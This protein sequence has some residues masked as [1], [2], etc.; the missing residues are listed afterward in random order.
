ML[1]ICRTFFSFYMHSDFFKNG[2]RPHGEPKEEKKSIGIESTDTATRISRQGNE[3]CNVC[4][5]I[6]VP[7]E[8]MVTTSNGRTEIRLADDV[9][10]YVQSWNRK[11]LANRLTD[12]LSCLI[13]CMTKNSYSL[14]VHE[15]INETRVKMP[16][17]NLRLIGHEGNSLRDESMETEF[18]E[19][20]NLV[21]T[22]SYYMAVSMSDAESHQSSKVITL[23]QDKTDNYLCDS[24]DTETSSPDSTKSQ[25]KRSQ[26]DS[27]ISIP[28]SYSQG[29]CS[30]TNSP[31]VKKDK[32]LKKRAAKFSEHGKYAKHS[33]TQTSTQSSAEEVGNTGRRPAPL[34]HQDSRE[35]QAFPSS[36]GFPVEGSMDDY[37]EKMNS[38]NTSNENLNRRGEEFLQHEEITAAED[39]LPESDVHSPY[40]EASGNHVGEISEVFLGNLQEQAEFEQLLPSAEDGDSVDSK[41]GFCVYVPSTSD[42][43]R[44]AILTQPERLKQSDNTSHRRDRLS[45]QRKIDGKDPTESDHNSNVIPD[46]S[47]DW[48]HDPSSPVCNS[49][50]PVGSPSA[51]DNVTQGNR[52]SSK[53]SK[54]PLQTSSPRE[55]KSQNSSHR[56]TTP[57]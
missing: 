1:S 2:P 11:G 20:S 25:V 26:S 6:P 5:Q 31:S 30:G 32:I 46:M 45:R 50:S 53:K 17:E 47:G 49:V 37:L 44:E 56:K 34:T 42:I 52:G 55:V 24:L 33:S 29:A 54:R 10:P 48:S 39:H 16:L 9:G 57:V 15:N 22:P 38:L 23:P 41:E 35:T 14:H 13:P 43:G 19:I 36:N 21:H 8:T 51:S 40:L 27:A 28:T 18:N 4:S 7:V 3:N 12:A